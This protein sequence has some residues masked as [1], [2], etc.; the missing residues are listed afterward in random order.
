M[1]FLPCD[2][3]GF[4]ALLISHMKRKLLPR[5]TLVSRHLLATFALALALGIGHHHTSS[6]NPFLLV[7][8][9]VVIITIDYLGRPFP[10][11]LSCPIVSISTSTPSLLRAHHLLIPALPAPLLPSNLLLVGL[12]RSGGIAW[13]PFSI[14]KVLELDR[15]IR[16]QKQSIPVT[17]SVLCLSCLSATAIPYSPSFRLP[18]AACIANTLVRVPAL[19]LAPKAP[20]TKHQNRSSTQR[21][22]SK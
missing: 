16:P 6:L 13:H 2:P 4:Q 20:S 10:L 18:A 3:V 11:T 8:L 9:L 17:L 5:T 21:L 12:S 7:P 1:N 22:K 19:G 14:S 15:L